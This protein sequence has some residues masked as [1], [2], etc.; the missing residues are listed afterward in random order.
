MTYSDDIRW[1]KEEKH[2][3]QKQ[4]NINRRCRKEKKAGGTSANEDEQKQEH[5]GIG[6]TI[7]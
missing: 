3:N 6:G 5:R 4:E 7:T 1:E 2:D